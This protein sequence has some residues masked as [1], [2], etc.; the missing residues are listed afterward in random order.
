LLLGRWDA[1]N[2]SGETHKYNKVVAPQR[3]I[4]S[5]ED[6]GINHFPARPSHYILAEKSGAAVTGLKDCKTTVSNHA[7]PL[8]KFLVAPPHQT[9]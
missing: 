8:S 6:F 1:G 3:F 2:V 5:N 9:I 4:Q 7:I